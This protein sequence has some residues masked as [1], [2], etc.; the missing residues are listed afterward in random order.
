MGISFVKAK[1]G[2]VY[3]KVFAGEWRARSSLICFTLMERGERWQEIAGLALANSLN[4]MGVFP[5]EK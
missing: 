3:G 4:V 2:G 1:E 5:L